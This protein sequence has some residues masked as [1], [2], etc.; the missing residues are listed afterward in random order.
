MAEERNHIYNHILKYTSLFGGVQGLNILVGI[1]RNKL[2]ALL[3][4]AEGMG[5]IALFNAT[6]KLL[7]DST[8][9]GLSMSA[10]REL[11][12]AYESNNIQLIRRKIAI[13]RLWSMLTALIGMLLCILLS[14]MLS[15]WVFG[16]G[17]HC[18]HFVLLS[19]VVALMALTGGE[20]AILKAIRQLKPLAKISFLHVVGALLTSIPLFY[21]WRE[22]AIVP[23]II[24]MALTQMLLTLYYTHKQYPIKLVFD[25]QLL[26]EGSP[27]LKIG[28]AFV[29]AGILG[30]GADFLVRRYL[31][32]LG[33]VET[34]GLYNAAY[35]MTMT[36]AGVIFSAMETDYFP[37]LSAVKASGKKMSNVVNT[38]IEISILMISP[39]LIVLMISIP[40]LLPLLYS[41]EF[42]IVKP[43]VQIVVLAMFLRAIKLPIAYIP[44]AKGNSKL[45]LLMEAL[46]DLGF[47]VAVIVGFWKYHLFGAGF[48]I[49]FIALL[50]FLMLFYFMHKAYGY[51]ISASV[52]KYGGTQCLIGL[53]AY[54]IV[55]IENRVVYWCLG[56][57]LVIISSAVSI[58]VLKQK[59]DI[60]KL[61]KNKMQKK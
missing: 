35:M 7:S 16:W 39:L 48:A 61:V 12:A 4:G 19:V 11:S 58:F 57:M 24:I 45:Y 34:V 38:Q 41:H 31:N 2:V 56:V 29:L 8:N 46:Y 14:P 33:S 32:I 26:V 3:L 5:L 50:D 27:M 37:R 21:I 17:N 49:T 30:S 22:A 47:V 15:K 20:L 42:I 55:Q 9:L 59:T 43:M 25:K 44:L 53:F 6:V 23:S 40:I 60:W 13:I 28:T 18:L 54:A 36:Y 52:L 10:I 51:I 1:V